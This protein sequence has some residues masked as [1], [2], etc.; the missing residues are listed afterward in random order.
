MRLFL[1]VPCGRSLTDKK[2]PTFRTAHNNHPNSPYTRLV[3]RVTD[4]AVR[5]T[6]RVA[7]SPLLPVLPG[8]GALM[9]SL[10]RPPQVRGGERCFIF[11]RGGCGVCPPSH[12]RSTH[13]KNTTSTTTN[14]NQKPNQKVKFGLDFGPALGGRYTA[15]PVAAF[16]DPFLRD[17][18]A[19]AL[20]WPQRCARGCFGGGEDV[21][22]GATLSSCRRL[23]FE[24]RPRLAETT[25][26]CHQKTKQNSV[27]VPLLPRAQTGP[28]DALALRSVGV[29]AVE[30]LGT[31][32]L[33]RKGRGAW[34]SA[35][36][37]QVC[38]YRGGGLFMI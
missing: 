21:G 8:F 18:L 11:G 5:G 17:T 32:G 1:S 37:P 33:P 38:G 2:S 12:T 30:V 26:T 10:A 27:V 16:L 29:A 19:S 34:L 15:R 6:A 28:L 23:L 13:T 22:A 31:R 3:P 35:V 24:H 4:L 9:F 7:L 36:D 25:T 20:V 14:T